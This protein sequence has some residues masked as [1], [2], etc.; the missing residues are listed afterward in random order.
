MANNMCKRRLGRLHDLMDRIDN[1][2]QTERNEYENLCD[3]WNRE[4]TL[5]W[6]RLNASSNMP[7][8]YNPWE[9]TYAETTK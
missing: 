6:S 9:S 1:L 8:D 4:E 3:E 2:T 7:H 5:S